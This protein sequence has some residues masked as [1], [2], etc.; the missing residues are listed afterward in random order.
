M[1]SDTWNISNIKEIAM[2][3]QIPPYTSFFETFASNQPFICN[4]HWTIK[5]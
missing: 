2:L 1:A 3:E 4:H 5:K